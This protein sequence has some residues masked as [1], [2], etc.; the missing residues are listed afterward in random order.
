[1]ASKE[2]P[3][4]NKP[5]RPP[6]PLSNAKIRRLRQRNFSLDQI[7]RAI[8]CSKST[9]ARRVRALAESPRREESQGAPEVAQ[10]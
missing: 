2:Q 1:M 5:G 3:R 6:I 7:A 10:T 9:A 8:G 4:G